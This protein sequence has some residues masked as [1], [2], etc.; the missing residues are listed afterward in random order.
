[1]KNMHG[2]SNETYSKI[3]KIID[4]YPEA[5]FKL[6]GSRAR[7]DFKYNSDI[8]LAVMNELKEDT[9]T[10]IR[11][12]IFMLETLYK[13]DLV[14][15]NKCGNNELIKNIENEGVDF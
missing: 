3:K 13:I 14:F 15:I 4:K 12:E 1:M 5:K 10:K 6:F 7:G 8:D 11:N 2:L 9:E